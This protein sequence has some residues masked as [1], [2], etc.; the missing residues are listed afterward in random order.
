MFFVAGVGGIIKHGNAGLNLM[1]LLAQLDPAVIWKPHV[2]DAKIE[3]ELFGEFQRLRAR[4]SR[5]D[6]VAKVA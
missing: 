6:D 4:S 1:D 5:G 3:L 2:Q